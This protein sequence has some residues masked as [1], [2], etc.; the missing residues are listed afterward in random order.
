MVV[1][2]TLLGLG[3]VTAKWV[4]LPILGLLLLA[5]AALLF[6]IPLSKVGH[7]D[8]Q[9][10]ARARASASRSGRGNP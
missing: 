6:G 8:E 9:L 7:T 5:L 2:A 10:V 3:V 1:A 4:V